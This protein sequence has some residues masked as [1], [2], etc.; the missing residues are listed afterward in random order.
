MRERD[1]FENLIEIHVYK[2]YVLQSATE[3]LAWLPGASKCQIRASILKD[4]DIELGKLLKS[5]FRTY[6]FQYKQ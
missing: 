3:A 4:Q 1:S 2:D 6:N 5:A